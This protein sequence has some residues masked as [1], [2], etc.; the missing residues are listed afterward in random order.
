METCR[1]YALSSSED[2]EIRYIGQTKLTISRRVSGHIS[3]SLRE[4]TH[5]ARWIQSVITAGHTI[6]ST[7]LVEDAEWCVDEMR[8]IQVHRVN[9]TRLTNATDGGEGMINPSAE[10]REKISVSLLGNSHALG[11]R[12]SQETRLSIAGS[13]T[14]MKRSTEQRAKM[15]VAQKGKTVS[16]ETREKIR[17]S[18]MGN[19]NAKGCVRTE[20]Q[21]A[22]MS[23]AQTGKTVTTLTKSRMSDTRR[24]QQGYFYALNLL[25]EV[26]YCGNSPAECHQLLFGTY[27]RSSIGRVLRGERSQH[28]AHKF[29]YTNTSQGI[30]I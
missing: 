11:H 3:N 24:A 5:K 17:N 19:T 25:N 30:A 2:G 27:D 14:G 18:A 8:L 22:N 13:H 9:G 28:R 29:E 20:L 21:R 16:P 7:I 10:T 1:V 23:A 15:S 6:E 12:H 26:V 4:K